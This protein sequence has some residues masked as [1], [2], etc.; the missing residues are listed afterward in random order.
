MLDK[1]IGHQFFESEF[2]SLSPSQRM[3]LILLGVDNIEQSRKFYEA[4]GWEKSATGH[5][6]FVKFD[7]GGYALCLLSKDDLAKDSLAESASC[8]GFSG[9]AFVYLAKYPD[10]VPGILKKAV[11]AGGTLVKPAT[12]T[13]WGIA[14]Y[15][16]DPDGY[17]FEVDYEEV[18]VF[19][20]QHHL[21]VDEVNERTC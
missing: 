10:D 18:W 8:N 6:G 21:I 16:K 17:L 5:D 7:L 13:P 20:E 14:G 11:E 9:V 12:R 15:F 19:D 4:I 2:Q 1:E 3:H